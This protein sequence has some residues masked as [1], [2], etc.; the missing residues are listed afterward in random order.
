MASHAE[1]TT[2]SHAIA[3]HGDAKYGP[4][5]KHFDYLNPNAPKGG[6]L[7]LGVQGT[8]DSFHPYI[9]KGNPFGGPSI[10]TLLT[11][12]ADEPFTEYGLIA[13]SIETPRDRSWVIFTLHKE[14]KWHDGQPITPEDVIWSLEILKTKGQPAYRFYYQ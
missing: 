12:S 9:S 13:E 1:E 7:R 2:I 4:K 11:S 8:F 14:A 6:R 5:F 10:E 3:M